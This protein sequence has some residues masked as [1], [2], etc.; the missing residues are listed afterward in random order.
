MGST[1]EV[2]YLCVKHLYVYTLQ[3]HSPLQNQ[4]M[5]ENF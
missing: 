2:Y 5:A 3:S 4:N 1:L